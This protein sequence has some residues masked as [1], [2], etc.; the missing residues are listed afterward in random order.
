MAADLMPEDTAVIPLGTTDNRHRG[1]HL[2]RLITA[3]V[4]IVALN[5]LIASPASAQGSIYDN[6]WTCYSDQIVV[7]FPHVY[8]N[9][10]SVVN[11]G[12]HLQPIVFKEVNGQWTFY[13]WINVTGITSRLGMTHTP[14]FGTWIEDGTRFSRVNYKVGVGPGKYMVG[15]RYRWESTD[16]NWFVSEL[17]HA[18]G[19]YICDI[20]K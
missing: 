18:P 10:M 5:G 6:G 8:L 2:R 7:N 20:P 19:T 14:L 3:V 13:S 12:V 15:I 4:M 1:K 16:W 11:E 9:D 17:S